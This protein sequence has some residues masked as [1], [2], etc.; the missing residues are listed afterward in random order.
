MSAAGQLGTDILG[1][2]ANVA[3]LLT[4]LRSPGGLQNALIN[5]AEALQNP[6]IRNTLM[7]NRF[8]SR[9]LGVGGQTLPVV[10]GRET[11]VPNL[12]QLGAERQ[13][14]MLENVAKLDALRSLTP[15]MTPE[16][17]EILLGF[18][19]PRAAGIP[20]GSVP[21]TEEGFVFQRAPSGEKF[22]V[23]AVPRP[24][25]MGLREA[26]SIFAGLDPNMRRQLAYGPTGP[27]VTVTAPAR[28]QPTAKG[29][30]DAAHRA[31]QIADELTP[32]FGK[33]GGLLV[34]LGVESP[35]D[36]GPDA[37]AELIGAMKDGGMIH[38]QAD[39]AEIIK[40][41]TRA[42]GSFN[43]E[44]YNA[45]AVGGRTQRIQG[46]FAGIE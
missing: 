25:P 35:E 22:K 17:K 14:G 44:A 10:P 36:W 40:S 20:V 39:P 34:S 29:R 18:R 7:G 2:G 1:R 16:Q 5:R 32:G 30:L 46:Y 24:P 19:G 33:E 11:F 4:A 12:P 28:L 43:R 21:I 3:S 42:D 9:A 13:V 31:G 37:Q 45:L 26:V 27:T 15:N 38:P 8:L 23:G 41:L 6:D